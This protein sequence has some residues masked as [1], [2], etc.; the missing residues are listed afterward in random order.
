MIPA[1]TLRLGL[2]Q[3]EMASAASLFNALLLLD[4][5]CSQLVPEKA[6]RVLSA[7][8]KGMNAA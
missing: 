3:P 8:T 2:K 4:V 5:E 7:G 1:S 6:A